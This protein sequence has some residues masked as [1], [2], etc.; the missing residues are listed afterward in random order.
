MRRLHRY[1]DIHV[2]F[3]MQ[4]LGLGVQGFLAE[5]TTRMRRSFL[6][7]WGS[8]FGIVGSFFSEFVKSP[9]VDRENVVVPRRAPIL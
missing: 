2:Q 9:H 3:H 5:E 6:G 4:D 8:F 1:I 7:I